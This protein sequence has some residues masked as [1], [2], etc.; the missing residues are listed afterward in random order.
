[1]DKQIDKQILKLLENIRDYLLADVQLSRRMFQE[2]Q[3]IGRKIGHILRYIKKTQEV[4]E[5][6]DKT[7]IK[8]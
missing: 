3:E 1:M 2:L 7:H 4:I 6:G 8:D 5:D